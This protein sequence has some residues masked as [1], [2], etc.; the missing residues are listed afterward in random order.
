MNDAQKPRR[1]S[2]QTRVDEE[3]EVVHHRKFVK[4]AVK[5]QNLGTDIF[6]P[7]VLTICFL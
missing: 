6:D 2:E 3:H 7:L 4:A 1:I 5:N